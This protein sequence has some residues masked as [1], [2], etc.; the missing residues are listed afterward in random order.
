MSLQWQPYYTGV[1]GYDASNKAALIIKGGWIVGEFY[2][3]ASARTAVYYLAS[4]GKT[5]TMMLTGRLALDYPGL[6]LSVSSLL[7]DP[8]WLPEGFPLSDERKAD[9]TIDQV[10]RHV[11]GIIPETEGN[12]ASSPLI[13]DPLWNFAPVTVGKDPDLPESAPLYFNPGEPGT[14]TAGRTYSSVAF[15]HFSLIFRNITGADGSLYL[16]SAMLDPIG[17]GRVAYKKASGMGGYIWATA[18][19]GLASAR[20]YARMAYL[21]LHEGT[22]AGQQIFTAE[23]IRQFTTVAGYPNTLANTDCSW[24]TQYPKDVYRII[25]S[26]VNIA[27]IVPS[28]DL[29][30]TLNGR[31][32]NGKKDE[33]SRAFLQKMFAAV[34]EQYVTCDGRTVDP[35]PPPA[36]PP[37]ATITLKV[38]G[39][40]DAVKQYM[41]LTWSGARGA[42][43]DIYR[44]GSFRNN[45]PNDGKQADNKLFTGPATYIYKICE[46]GTYTCSNPASVSFNGGKLPSNKAPIPVFTSTG[47]GL[48]CTF[49]D[50][51]VDLDGSLTAWKWSFGDGTDGSERSPSHTYSAPGTYPVTL[52]VTDDRGASRSTTVGTTVA[53]P[54]S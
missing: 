40:S 28:L 26:G 48:T 41:T 7:Y 39:R 44:N 45:T 29:I 25:G 2:N 22:W 17:V 21:L 47:A 49:S 14:Y 50:G 3:Q 20:D 38:T 5:L 54:E 16:R 4:N 1:S 8:R 32:A 12:V 52:T 24:G 9:I 53:A 31:F 35:P 51:S 13:N 10:F 37:P 11:S 6:N 36:A 34:R 27:F 33:I 46:A 30:G 18:G 15:N 42:T 43:V 23:W 19:N